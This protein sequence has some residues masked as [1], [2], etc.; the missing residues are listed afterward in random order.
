M[1]TY[2][3]P[4]IE[5]FHIGFECEFKNQMQSN[6][7][8]KQICDWSLLL[9]ALD[10]DGY[11]TEEFPDIF[12]IK[13]LDQQDCEELGWEHIGYQWYNL[14]VV[15]GKLGYWAYVRLRLEGDNSFIKAYRYD[16]KNMQEDIQE[17]DY[18]FKGTIRN[19]SELKQVMKLVKCL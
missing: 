9:I 12:R 17:K 6:E 13:V 11:N 7:W 4:K 10:E 2:Y 19:K 14:K 1:N 8:E 18:L 15:P 16:P 5:D 3:T